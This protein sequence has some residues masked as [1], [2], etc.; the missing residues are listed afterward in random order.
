MYILKK[1]SHSQK[2]NYSD[3][4][5]V[6]SYLGWL[7][8]CNGKGLDRKYFSTLR[9]YCQL[10]YY[11]IIRGEKNENLLRDLVNCCAERIRFESVQGILSKEYLVHRGRAPFNRR[12]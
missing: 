12:R 7:K 11:K 1:L 10:Y 3:W 8:H 9:Y 6:N 5:A 4:C 2:M